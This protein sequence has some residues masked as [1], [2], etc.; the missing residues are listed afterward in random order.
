MTKFAA[1]SEIL[2]ERT[3]W[4]PSFDLA[5]NSR[6]G[7]MP[8]A[9]LVEIGDDTSWTWHERIEG[10]WVPSIGGFGAGTGGFMPWDDIPGAGA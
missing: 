7:Q 8:D 10:E 5:A 4:L 2:N 1:Y 9:V 3:P 6:P